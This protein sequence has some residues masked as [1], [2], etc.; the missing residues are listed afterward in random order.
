VFPEST[1]ITLYKLKKFSDLDRGEKMRACYQHACL[2]YAIGKKMTNASLR[3]RFGIGDDYVAQTSRLIRDSVNAKL[4]KPSDDD[5]NR[6]L[7]IPAWA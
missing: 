1:V 7:Y 2:M 3:E 5:P 4:I 6:R